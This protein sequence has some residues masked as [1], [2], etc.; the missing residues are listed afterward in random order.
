MATRAPMDREGLRRA[1][2]RLVLCASRVRNSQAM[3]LPRALSLLLSSSVIA[4][5]NAPA[6]APAD[7]T[8]DALVDA[9]PDV[10]EKDDDRL[11][12]PD[13]VPVVGDPRALDVRRAGPYHAGHR[14]FMHTYT[15][16]GATAPRT[17]PVHVWYPT[18]A[19]RGHHP[20]Y[21]RFFT[22]PDAIDDAPPAPVAYP[23]GYP[24]HAYSHGYQGFAGSTHFLMVYFATHGWVSV[25]PDHVGNT[26]LG[27][28]SP[29]PLAIQHL[30]SQDMRAALDM[31]EALPPSDPL[32]RRADTR[33]VVLSGH[34]FGT[35]T[36]WASAGAT[37]DVDAI[38]PR[39]TP[40]VSCGPADLAVFREGLRDAR[41]VAGIPMA[42]SISR[43]F[44][45]PTGHSSVRI[46]LLAMSGTADPVGDEAQFM[47]TAGVDL[48]WIEVEGGCHQYFGLGGCPL[49]PDDQQPLIAGAW[50]L[51]FARRHVLNDDDAT[52]RGILD[53]TLA[54]SPRVTLHRRP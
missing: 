35:H 28:L 51:A 6:P 49:I 11:V 1:P 12:V 37:F 50:A 25:A 7:A 20:T 2:I 10:P 43:D 14:V 19:V 42:G 21:E 4:G 9:A 8:V 22:D 32:A 47:T 27:N 33:R 24:V 52:V 45:G 15:P 5:C 39:C 29:L 13:D 26:L 41:V 38:T 16:R 34:S 48:T 18:F 23:M 17:I 44:F 3:R 40:Q 46:P 30:R 54:L 36:V 53:G 31:L